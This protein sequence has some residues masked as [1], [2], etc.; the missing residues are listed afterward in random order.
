MKSKLDVFSKVTRNVKYVILGA[1]APLV[2]TGCIS[3]MTAAI[4]ID[5]TNAKA[6]DE[7][8]IAGAYGEAAALACED[9]DKEA[10]LDEANLLPTLYAG[11]SLLFDHNYTGSLALLNESEEIIKF[12]HEEAIAGN[13]ADYIAKLAI[14]DAAIDYHATINESIMV[15][16]YKA[17]DY[18][19]LGKFGSARI[20]L[21]RA[22][23][24]QR[25]AKNT[26]AKLIGQQKKA[27]NKKKKEKEVKGKDGKKNTGFSKTLSNAKIKDALKKN[28]SNLDQFKAYPDFVNPFTTYLAGLYFAIQGDYSK[29]SSL[30]KQT[31]GMT[32]NKTV[33]SDFKMVEKALSGRK[34][35]DK[36]VWVIYENGL[37]PIKSQFKINIPMYLFPSANIPYVGIALPKLETRNQ[38]TPYLSVF[39]QNKELAK[40]SIV[41][42]MDRV[43][44]TEFKYSYNDVLTRAVLSA[45][46]KAY[47]QHEL[48]K[49]AG[50]MGKIGGGITTFLTTQADTRNWMNMPKDFQVARVKMPKSKKLT[51]KAGTQNLDVEIGKKAKHAIVHVR[52]P[53][54]VSK[55]SVSV[56]NF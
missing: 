33:K 40:T 54:A 8:F 35:R 46:I 13:I 3:N 53:T 30:L 25:R 5:S 15:N 6:Q 11:N 4:G 49:H 23:D 47:A 24:R 20:E 14:N 28:Y 10:K 32:K 56:I 7:K 26:Y 34:V 27:I 43:V 42:E 2:F 19:A 1:I 16:T 44:K 12:H 39:S 29:S 51:L 21:N 50:I 37:G 38:A 41:G 22:I 31:Y 52:I 9:K 45:I 18:M 55:P 17:I 36:Y 48:S